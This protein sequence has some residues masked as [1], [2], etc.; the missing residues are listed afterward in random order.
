MATPAPLSVAFFARDTLTVARD[1]LGCQ[2]WTRVC[3]EVAGGR[4]VEVE[5]YLGTDDPA[6]HAG[7][8]P[9]PRSAIM[10]GKPGVAYVY[11]VYGMHHCLN[12]VTERDGVAGAVLLRA[13]EPVAGL[14]LMGARAGRPRPVR[15][16]C[17]GPG[18]LCRALGVT[19]ACNGRFLAGRRVRAAADIQ[20]WI[21]ASERP[22]TAVE[23]TGRIG[24]RQA[25]ERPW[26]FCDAQSECLS[27]SRPELRRKAVF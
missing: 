2:L 3:G 15:D 16:L 17:R 7:R 26:R 8:G 12:A 4:I 20:V 10:F 6:S 1:L 14:P 9:T 27:A 21:S 19:R 25:A 23:A 5:A 11:M 13:L 24:V 18:R 22:V